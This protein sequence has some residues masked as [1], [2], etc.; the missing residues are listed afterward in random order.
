MLALIPSLPFFF[1]WHVCIV[2]V[3]ACSHIW[4]TCVEVS[5]TSRV[6]LDP[7]LQPSM[8]TRLFW[9]TLLGCSLV[10]VKHP[11][12]RAILPLLSLR[13]IPYKT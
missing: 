7:S 12:H 11:V 8:L 4:G 9:E 5:L 13:T 3:C 2:C 6:S 10:H 1:F